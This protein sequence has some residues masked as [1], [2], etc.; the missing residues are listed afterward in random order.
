MTAEGIPEEQIAGMIG[1]MSMG[2]KAEAMKVE[3]GAA[4]QRP[5]DGGAQDVDMTEPMPDT[6]SDD[7][8]PSERSEE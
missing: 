5:P 4:D 1:A 7:E 6:D 3:P 8:N 2:T